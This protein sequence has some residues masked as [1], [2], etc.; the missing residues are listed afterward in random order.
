MLLWSCDKEAYILEQ[1]EVSGPAAEKSVVVPPP[2]TGNYPVLVGAKRN[3]P[4]K[5][6]TMQAVGNQLM[7]QGYGTNADYFKIQTTHIYK[8][9]TIESEASLESL[10]ESDTNITFYPYPL[11]YEIAGTDTMY[12]DSLALEWYA[13]VPVSYTLNDNKIIQESIDNLYLPT[14]ETDTDDGNFS[15]RLVKESL[16]QTGNLGEWEDK[17]SSWRPEGRITVDDPILNQTI[18]IQGLR[19]K[20]RRWFTTHEGYT[21][22]KGFFVCNGTFKRKARYHFDWERYQFKIRGMNIDVEGP[23]SDQPWNRKVASGTFKQS[24]AFVFMA[25]HRYYYKDL[26]DIH[27]PPLNSILKPQMK[28]KVLDEAKR[29]LHQPDHRF[30][31][32]GN[33]IKI[34]TK[35]KGLLGTRNENLDLLYLVTLHE[36]AHAA[37]WEIFDDSFD[38][39]DLIV[40]ESWAVAIAEK[41]I[42]SKYPGFIRFGDFTYGDLLAAGGESTPLYTSIFIDLEDDFN[43]GV[44]DMLK[45]FDVV[46]GYTLSQIESLLDS[47]EDFNC[48]QQ[49]LLNDFDN[50]TE[51]SVPYLFQQHETLSR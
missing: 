2:P 28:I 31:G 38:D 34:Y 7:A 3:N 6:S 26:P 33:W 16:R 4:Y 10:M 9:F 20:A 47:C 29:S 17:R 12:D 41:L 30:L 42:Q 11:D 8:K 35:V 19:V 40:K 48:I 44:M 36:L 14:D 45:P 37:H 1:S 51:V 39:I 15:D 5:V 24:V 32:M 21:N 25:A 46:E 50:P 23:R 27:L 22:E 49:G 43:Q 13:A 18:G